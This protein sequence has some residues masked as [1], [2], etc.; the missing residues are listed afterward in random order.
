MTRKLRNVLSRG[1][2]IPLTLVSIHKGRK[3]EPGTSN[4]NAAERHNKSISL[5]N[6]YDMYQDIST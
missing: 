3:I 2:P 1:K 4:L 5:R 6:L